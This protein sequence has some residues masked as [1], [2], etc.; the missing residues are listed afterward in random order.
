MEKTTSSSGRMK[1]L[2]GTPIHISKDYCMEKWLEN[3]SKLEY[4]ADL[5][6]VDNSLGLQYAEKVKGYCAK[7][8]LT[9][10]KIIHLEIPERGK[11]IHEEIHERI[12]RS[13]EIIRQYFLSGDYDAWFC[14]ECDQII[15]TNAL[16]ELVKLMRSGDFWV[17]VHNCWA[18]NDIDF[19]FD[20]GVALIKRNI[21][22][23]YEF[24]P[25]FGT[26][27]DV[28]DSWYNAEYW[29]KERLKKDGCRY[30]EVCGLISPIYHLHNR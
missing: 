12:C 5:L 24:L 14:W 21:L 7:Y 28:P 8:G 25:K 27:P 23:K 2:I 9:N 11:G 3:V 1:I 13:R 22:E 17:I 18:E 19:N 4:P 16:D 30:A 6:M 10:Y 15:P 26:D 20:F 29:F